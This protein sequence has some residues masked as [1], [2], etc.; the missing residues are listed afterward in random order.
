MITHISGFIN[1][2]LFDNIA[3][4]DSYNDFIRL[5]FKIGNKTGTLNIR[6]CSRANWIKKTDGFDCFPV[7]TI[8]FLKSN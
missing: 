1:S 5:K 4:S 8:G 3:I 7:Y 2:I 6:C